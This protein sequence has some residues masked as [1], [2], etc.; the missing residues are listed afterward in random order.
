MLAARDAT[1]SRT[2]VGAVFPNEG[3]DHGFDITIPVSTIGTH[4][5]DVYA[6]DSTADGDNPLLGRTTVVVTAPVLP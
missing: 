4:T 5:V 6:I 1:N 2:D 3:S